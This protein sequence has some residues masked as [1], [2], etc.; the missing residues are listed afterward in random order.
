MTTEGM[1]ETEVKTPAELSSWYVAL[2]QLPGM[3]V[4]LRLAVLAVVTATVQQMPVFSRRNHLWAGAPRASAASEGSD[5]SVL[6]VDGF[7]DPAEPEDQVPEASIEAEKAESAFL[8]S[9]MDGS[10]LTGETRP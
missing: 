6:L 3:P 10:R 9:C 1:Q 7:P 5:G 8:A 2:A 4:K